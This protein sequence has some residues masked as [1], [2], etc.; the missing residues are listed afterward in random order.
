MAEGLKVMALEGHGVAFLPHSAV[1]KEL[2]SRRVVPAAPAGLPGLEM[3]M[4]IRA[5]REKPSGR[6]APKRNAQALW[7]FLAEQAAAEPNQR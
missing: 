1:K 3:A 7:A 2:R 6:E 5:Y 4:D